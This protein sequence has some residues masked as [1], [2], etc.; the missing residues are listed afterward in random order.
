MC[1]RSRP[2]H[3]RQ[4][5]CLELAHQCLAQ[6]N[7]SSTI[8]MWSDVWSSPIH[9]R[10]ILLDSVSGQ[11]WHR[12]MAH[13]HKL[14]KWKQIKNIDFKYT[15]R[16]AGRQMKKILI[17]CKFTAFECHQGRQSFNFITWH[18]H[19]VANTCNREM[20]RTLIRLDKQKNEACWLR[21]NRGYHI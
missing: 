13:R 2:F 14:R 20:N 3:V 5:P 6:W 4:C 17:E 9:E 11:P 16:V 15:L 19:W 8:P 1:R 18:V 12:R 10:C 21:K 7:P